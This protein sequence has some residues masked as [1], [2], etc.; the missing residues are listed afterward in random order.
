MYIKFTAKPFFV[1]HQVL[2]SFLLLSCFGCRDQQ[3][4][5]NS[6][7][8]LAMEW[9][10]VEQSARGSE[11]TFMMWQGSP[12]LNAYMNDF[13]KPRLKTLYGIDLKIVG[14]QGAEI[15][16]LI[17]G[18]KQANIKTGEVD[19]VWINGETYFQLKEIT[20]LWGPFVNKLPNAT[21]VDFEN[22]FISIDFQQPIEG[23]EAPWS[24]T[25]FALVH[26]SIKHPI[27]PSNLV[28]LATFV[29][30]NPGS[31]TISNDF[32][33]MTLLKSFLA[34]LSG[35]P[36]GLNGAYDEEKYQKLS[37]KL[38]DWINKNKQYF[39]KNGETFP[40]EHTKLNQMYANGEL[41]L[42][43]GFGE[44]G[45]DD[46]INQGLFPKSTKAYP[47]KNGTIKNTNYL[48]ITY[49]G[50]HKLGAMVV[51]NF[52]MS[53]EAQL[54]KSDVNGVNANSVLN[55][56]KLSRSDQALFD[57]LPIRKYGPSIKSMESNAIQEPD[58]QYMIKLYEDFRK[59]V[60]AVK[61]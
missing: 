39:W 19:M 12:E 37:A 35:S 61:N 31:F 29:K 6:E 58:P 43:Y 46:K 8:I 26:D 33:G 22:K 24:I 47:W 3:P 7:D 15:V 48:G 56:S 50:K 60:I 41:S 45:I 28:D 21:L 51:I 20:G 4:Q 27:P 59:K 40:T 18:E 9:P 55:Y 5:F 14:G 34:E 32:S 25:Q 2:L 17:M 36:D 49:N 54:A 11:V 52:L 42:S 13:V 23:M 16:Q 30:Q 1:V 57:Q 38:W 44:G 10:Q 53:P